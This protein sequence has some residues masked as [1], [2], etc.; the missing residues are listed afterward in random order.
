MNWL[1]HFALS[2]DGDRIRLG[3]WLA[4]LFSRSE[5]EGVTDDALRFG[6]ELHQ[7]IDRE[8]DRHPQV[9]AARARFPPELRRGGGI[10]LDV[11]W[12]HFLAREFEHRMGRAL[13]SF[14]A[15]VLTGLERVIHLGPPGTRDVLAQ[16]RVENWL[17]SYET[18]EGVELALSRISRRLSPRARG[19][20]APRAAREFLLEHYS[21]LHADFDE[22]WNS[23]SVSVSLNRPAL[24]AP[25]EINCREAPTCPFPG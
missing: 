5:L 19:V 22:I 24:C 12:D 18:P 2:P 25:T 8:T 7:R 10:V 6:L 17:G 15:E 16:M 9:R 1:A 4:D 14:V 11:F 20:L 13:N 3:N 21:V 23:V